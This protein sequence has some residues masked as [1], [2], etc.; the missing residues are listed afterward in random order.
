[1]G[2]MFINT[3]DCKSSSDFPAAKKPRPGRSLATSTRECVDP[4]R[5]RGACPKNLGSLL[6]FATS[7]RLF[8]QAA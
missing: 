6:A 4:N 2:A 7:N 1:M 8:R 5:L 3:P